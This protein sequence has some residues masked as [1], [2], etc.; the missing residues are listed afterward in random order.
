M[1]LSFVTGRF[2]GGR[3]GSGASS[4]GWKLVTGLRA[5]EGLQLWGY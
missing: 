3:T 2:C 4:A 5:A 1:A